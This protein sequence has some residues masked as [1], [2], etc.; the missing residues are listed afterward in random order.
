MP[1]DYRAA[2]ISINS[3][4]ILFS[5]LADNLLFYRL[6]YSVIHVSFVLNIMSKSLFP[7]TCALEIKTSTMA[8]IYWKNILTRRFFKVNSKFK[9]KCATDSY[10]SIL[11]PIS[12]NVTW[13]YSNIIY[14]RTLIVNLEFEWRW[15][16]DFKKVINT[17]I[18]VI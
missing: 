14:D 3:H 11:R 17:I 6:P 10:L 1:I 13:F 8:Y 12:M 16:F 5:I 18:I 4:S 15:N 9:I 7:A 2:H